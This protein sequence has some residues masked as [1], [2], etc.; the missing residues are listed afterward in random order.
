MMEEFND[1]DKIADKWEKA[2]SNCVIRGAKN[3]AKKMVAYAP[4]DTGFLRASVYVVT[5]K[6]STYGKGRA[7]KMGRRRVNLAAVHEL[8]TEIARPYDDQTAYAAVG[9]TYGECVNYGTRFMAAQPFFEPAIDD[10]RS[11]FENDL[12]KIEEKLGQ[13]AGGSIEDDSF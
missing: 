3:V 6:S 1:W 7:S 4:V 2:I 11:D 12:G 5:W 9:A 10:S 13:S 8:H